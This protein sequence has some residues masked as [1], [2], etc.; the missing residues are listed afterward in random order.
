MKMENESRHLDR[1]TEPSAHRSRAKPRANVEPLDV[2][3][4]RHSILRKLLALR[5]LWRECPDRACRRAR[6]CAS[7]RLS[8]ADLPSRR[9][10]KPMTPQR[11]AANLAHLQR[12]L[13][14]RS[15]ELRA[16]EGK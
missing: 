10:D 13:K 8:C 16:Q 5:E 6:T 14:R 15:A 4:L 9:R 7:P 12:L 1:K 11:E 3:A 2:D